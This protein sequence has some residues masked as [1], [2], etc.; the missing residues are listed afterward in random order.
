[1][2]AVSIGTENVPVI[3]IRNVP[4]RRLPRGGSGATRCG[5][6]MDVGVPGVVMRDD[7]RVVALQPQ[8]LQSLVRRFA[9]SPA[10]RASRPS[11]S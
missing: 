9:S 7:Q 8:H 6:H 3:G 2:R 1:M 5:H 10:A 4:V 11:A